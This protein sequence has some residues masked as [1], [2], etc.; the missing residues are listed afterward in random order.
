MLVS[1]QAV[2]V[3]W[4]HHQPTP[5]CHVIC[6]QLSSVW[7]GVSPHALLF[8]RT[9]WSCSCIISLYCLSPFYACMYMYVHVYFGKWSE[10]FCWTQLCALSTIITFPVCVHACPESS[11]AKLLFTKI[12]VRENFVKLSLWQLTHHGNHFINPLFALGLIIEEK[13]RRKWVYTHS[14]FHFMK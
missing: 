9:C 2:W 8:S 14:G 1:S 12:L 5:G 11:Q 4:T 3:Q 6:Q 10:P 7:H 13:V